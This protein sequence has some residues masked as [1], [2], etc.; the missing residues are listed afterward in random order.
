MRWWLTT[1]LALPAAA[2]AQDAPPKNAQGDVAVTIYNNNLALIQDTRQLS[3][4]AGVS[5]QD[6]EI[7]PHRAP[8][9]SLTPE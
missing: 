2:I 7:R 9:W 8:F 3:L 6:F 1:T 5:R 4:P